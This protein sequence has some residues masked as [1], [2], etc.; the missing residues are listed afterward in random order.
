V[1]A[2]LGAEHIEMVIRRALDIPDDDR[3]RVANSRAGRPPSP[4]LV[5][6]RAVDRRQNAH[7]EPGPSFRMQRLPFV[8]LRETDPRHRVSADIDDRVAYVPQH[9]RLVGRAQDDPAHPRRKKRDPFVPRSAS[10]CA[11]GYLGSG[12]CG[13]SPGRG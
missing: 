4:P 10:R 13:A 9:L 7:I 3:V 11:L 1:R 2:G 6:P 12:R 5:R 8:V